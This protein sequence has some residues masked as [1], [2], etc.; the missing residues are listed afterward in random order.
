MK[1]LKQL[2]F[3]IIY[4]VCICLLLSSV[5]ILREDPN[6]ML[7]WA[8]FIQIPITLSI[9][10]VAAIFGSWI[11]WKNSNSM[12]AIL[13][14]SVLVYIII[15]VACFFY[16]FALTSY[17]ESFIEVSLSNVKTSFIFSIIFFV[18]SCF[19]KIIQRYLSNKKP[20]QQNHNDFD[21]LNFDLFK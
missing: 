2:R 5:F 15:F 14:L 9:N 18:F 16:K 4:A 19:I 12:F 10:I 1:L 8:F 13:I 7:F 21:D 6:L 11:Q 3:F 17:H 20:T